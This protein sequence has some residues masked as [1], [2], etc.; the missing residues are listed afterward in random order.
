ME[1]E[2]ILYI[3]YGSI[4]LLLCTLICYI[5]H[6]QKNQ[7]NILNRITPVEKQNIQGS[8]EN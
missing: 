3:I 4:I 8:Q 2:Y 1:L 6:E 7:H 5:G